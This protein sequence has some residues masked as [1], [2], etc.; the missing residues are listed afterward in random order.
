MGK[1]LTRSHIVKPKSKIIYYSFTKFNVV[2]LYPDLKI[3][4]IASSCPRKQASWSNMK[5]L[6]KSSWSLNLSKYAFALAY[7][8]KDRFLV[9]FIATMF[10]VIA[11]GNSSL[12]IFNQ[13]FFSTKEC[14][15]P[16]RTI[17]WTPDLNSASEHKIQFFQQLADF[18]FYFGRCHFIYT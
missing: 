1:S 10:I 7:S 11:I 15:N 5:V 17:P 9:G 4:K 13:K 16:E 14:T 12:R 2:Y 6:R 3:S 8:K 18:G